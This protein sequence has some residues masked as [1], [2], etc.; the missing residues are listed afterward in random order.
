LNYTNELQFTVQEILSTIN[1]NQLVNI[2]NMDRSN[3]LLARISDRTLSTSKKLDKLSKLNLIN[4]NIKKLGKKLSGSG[5]GGATIAGVPA[6]QLS[7]LSED[8]KNDLIIAHIAKMNA[9]ITEIRNKAITE[10]QRATDIVHRTTI[11]EQNKLADQARKDTADLKH[12]AR[13][14]SEAA[15]KKILD[16]KK[17]TA[18]DV[19]TALKQ[20]T[21]KLERKRKNRIENANRKRQNKIAAQEKLRKDALLA[22]RKSVDDKRSANIDN[23]IQIRTQKFLDITIDK[24]NK[25]LDK[26]VEE[27]G[28]EFRTDVQQEPTQKLLNRI[29]KAIEIDTEK[30]HSIFNMAVGHLSHL[31]TDSIKDREDKKVQAKKDEYEATQRN[32]LNDKIDDTLRKYGMTPAP[33]TQTQP[34][35]KQTSILDMAVGNLIT[36]KLWPFIKGTFAKIGPAIGSLVK[37]IGGIGPWIVGLGPKIAAATKAFLLL[38]PPATKLGMLV[39]KLTLATSAALAAF[40]AL[41]AAATAW[42]V[43]KNAQVFKDWRK[44][45]SDTKE[46]QKTMDNMD[47]TFFDKQ[48]SALRENDNYSDDDIEDIKQRV[49]QKGQKHLSREEFR[50]LLNRKDESGKE[51]N[52]E[53]IRSNRERN[54]QSNAQQHN[55]DDLSSI[56]TA[57]SEGFAK[58]SPAP[59][60]T[61]IVVPPSPVYPS[62]SA[63]AFS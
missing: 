41:A 59:Q 8:Q 47:A 57:I 20:S 17:Q 45:V 21:A 19:A 12:Q 48:L 26:D 46:Q 30:T 32:I 2:K 4:E 25:K 28:K 33:R 61:T 1:A 50:H 18:I 39:G 24:L 62:Y 52:P 3:E 35:Q 58:V 49:S 54:N 23:T 53:F 37:W 5:D 38:T 7:Q 40:T 27:K 29:A 55:G 14:D 43:W 16:Q 6:N 42:L 60:K 44:T 51:F 22:S 13:K 63:V 34:P 15:D 31:V 56:S 10:A 9:E 36:Q 11:I